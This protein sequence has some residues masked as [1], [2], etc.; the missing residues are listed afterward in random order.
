MP[1]EAREMV[2]F[3]ALI[4]DTTTRNN[5]TTLTSTDIMCFKKGCSGMIKTALIPNTSEI[6]WYCLDC[7]NEG[8]I[9][10]WQKTKWSNRSNY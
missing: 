3:L 5:P 6:H 8:V 7:E 1:K 4:I 2:S 9:S 10:E